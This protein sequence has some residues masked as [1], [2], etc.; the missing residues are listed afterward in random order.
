MFA[1]EQIGILLQLLPILQTLLW[2]FIAILN[3]LE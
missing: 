1:E 2:Y 3:N